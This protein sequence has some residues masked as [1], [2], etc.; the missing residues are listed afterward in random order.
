MWT[1]W[2]HTTLQHTNH[3]TVDGLKFNSKL[4]KSLS[5]TLSFSHRYMQVC[6]C[7]CAVRCL[8]L[9]LWF[10]KMQF[11]LMCFTWIFEQFNGHSFAWLYFERNSLRQLFSS[12]VLFSTVVHL[13]F[14]V[15]GCKQKSMVVKS[16]YMKK[17]RGVLWSSAKLQAIQH[18][19]CVCVCLLCKVS[20]CSQFL[21][22]WNGNGEKRMQKRE[23]TKIREKEAKNLYTQHIYSK[24]NKMS[25]KKHRGK[26]NSE[27]ENEQAR[28]RDRERYA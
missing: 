16:T 1:H 15:F 21:I 12:P 5:R 26:G 23:I 19:A 11:G 18:T 25:G 28:K 27:I 3:W 9:L 6:V 10:C 14:T 22:S 4:I 24:A 17:N 13:Y 20:L 2:T 7:V 8:Q